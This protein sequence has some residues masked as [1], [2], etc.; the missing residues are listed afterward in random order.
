MQKKLELKEWGQ[1][2]DEDLSVLYM[3]YLEV[4]FEGRINSV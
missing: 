3:I 2:L 4:M 1:T